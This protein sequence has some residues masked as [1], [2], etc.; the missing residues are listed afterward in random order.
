MLAIEVWELATLS[1]VARLETEGRET[2]YL[3]FTPD[4]RYLISADSD[5]LRLWDLCSRRVVARRAA[6][7]RFSGSFG[8]SF[9]SCLAV[10]P[11]GSAVATGQLDTAILLWDLSPPKPNHPSAPLTI[12]EREKHWNDLAGADAGRAFTASAALADAPA[13]T[14]AMLRNRLHPAQAPAAEELRKLLADL[15]HEQFQRREAA[16]NVCATWAN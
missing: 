3:A 15:D 14:V 11:N 5:A 16:T 4:S 10:A 6:P 7:G 13:Q 2:G 1:R 9:A 8:P 12:A